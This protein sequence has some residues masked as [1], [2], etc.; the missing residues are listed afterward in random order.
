M[1]KAR[2]VKAEVVGKAGRKK[3]KGSWAKI[4]ETAVAVL[5]KLKLAVAILLDAVDLVLANIPVLNTLWDFVTFAVLMLM[6]KNKWIAFGAFAELPLIGLPVMGQIDAVIP[7]ATILTI[8]DS[9]ETKF[10]IIEKIEE[11]R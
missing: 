9:A 4:K 1:E 10:H 5:L 2:K 11:F 6:L 3:K 7:I 8:L